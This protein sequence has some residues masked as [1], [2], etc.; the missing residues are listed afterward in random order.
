[1]NSD[2]TLSGWTE[3]QDAHL[4]EA[5]ETH[6]LDAWMKV[7]KFVGEGKLVSDVTLKTNIQIRRRAEFLGLLNTNKLSFDKENSSLFSFDDT[8]ANLPMVK[9]SSKLVVMTPARKAALVSR[10]VTRSGN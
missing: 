1:M 3:S 9:E 2:G 10:R 5:L 8:E 7:K 6:G 4:Q